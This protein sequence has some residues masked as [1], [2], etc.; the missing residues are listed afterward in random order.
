MRNYIALGTEHIFGGLDHIAFLLALVLVC[1][2]KRDLLWA[3]TGFTLGHSLTL[4]FA[5]LGWV[6]PDM[7]LVEAAIGFTIALVAVEKVA[8]TTDQGKR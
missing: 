3:I 7:S 5:S 4:A 6:A 8:A 2:R 1:G